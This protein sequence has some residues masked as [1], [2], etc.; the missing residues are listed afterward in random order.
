M[1]AAEILNKYDAVLP[2]GAVAKMLDVAVQTLRMYEHEGLVL[3][4]RTPGGRRLYSLHDVQKLRCI[5]KMITEQSMN[6]SGIRKVLSMIPCWEFMGGLDE[7]CLNCPAYTQASG[8]CWSVREVGAK[9]V[10]QDCRQCEVYR[11]DF[12]CQNLKD[13]ITRNRTSK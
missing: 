5:R 1:E 10:R 11:L 3:P 8:P 13:V 4:E 6:I 12:D 9:C 7:D 2:I